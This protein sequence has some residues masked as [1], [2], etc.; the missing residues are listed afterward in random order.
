MTPSG[1]QPT[2]L[3]PEHLS[4]LQDAGLVRD[5]GMCHLPCEL[6]WEGTMLVPAEPCAS[7]HQCIVS[8]R[9][10]NMPVFPF[11]CS[12]LRHNRPSQGLPSQCGLSPAGA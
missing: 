6:P 5:Q 2:V 12:Y 1:P 11:C 7:T 4:S 8:A 3:G 10:L 9:A